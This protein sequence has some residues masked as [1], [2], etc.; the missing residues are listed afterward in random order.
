MSVLSD[1]LGLSQKGSRVM[2]RTSLILGTLAVAILGSVL[3]VSASSQDPPC[4]PAQMVVPGGE[5]R[6]AL[7]TSTAAGLWTFT[8]E[9]VK[10]SISRVD[11]Q[12]YENAR[13]TSGKDPDLFVVCA[14]CPD[15][16]GRPQADCGEGVPCG[17]ISTAGS[18]SIKRV[19]VGATAS[20]TLDDGVYCVRPA[21]FGKGEVTVSIHP[22]Q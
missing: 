13:P 11:I 16:Y 17:P 6:A 9:A 15:P 10:G 22:A 2:K 18:V 14:S 7:E 12:I 4:F 20:I 5:S 8:I 19:K 1:M 3:L 21:A